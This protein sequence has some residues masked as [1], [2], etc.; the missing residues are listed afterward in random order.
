MPTMN[1]F[2]D[3]ALN[4][5]PLKGETKEAFQVVSV[6][7]G[8]AKDI[9]NMIGYGNYDGALQTLKNYK[10]KVIPDLEKKLKKLQKG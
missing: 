3:K 9:Q 6:L 7:I 1:E 10:T 4:E 2:L 5:A 8:W